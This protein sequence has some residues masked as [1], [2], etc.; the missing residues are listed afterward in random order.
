MDTTD[1]ISRDDEFWRGHV[2]KAVHEFSGSNEEYCRINGLPKSPFYRHKKRLGLTR[3]FKP[4]N[5]AFIKIAPV[6]PEESAVEVK[7][8]RGSLPDPKWTAEFVSSLMALR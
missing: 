3:P 8:K 1:A 4:S 2:L 5:R 6:K 7:F